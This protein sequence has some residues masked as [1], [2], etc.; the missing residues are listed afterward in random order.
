MN[1]DDPS[2]RRRW[3]ALAGLSAAAGAALAVGLIPVAPAFADPTDAAVSAVVPTSEETLVDNMVLADG[4]TNGPA[5]AT[6]INAAFGEFPGGVHGTDATLLETDLVNHPT[7]LADLVSF[8]SFF[9]DHGAQL[10][11]IAMGDAD[12]MVY[13]ADVFLG[14]SLPLP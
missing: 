9:V 6:A 10:G 13:V 8:D 2:Q 1:H 5:D 14:Q 3:G 7:L 11:P 12:I 4:G